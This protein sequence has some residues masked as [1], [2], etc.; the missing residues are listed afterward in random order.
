MRII[1]YVPTDLVLKPFIDIGITDY[2]FGHVP[3]FWKRSYS[4]ANS[5]NRR[6]QFEGQIGPLRSIEGLL[7]KKWG[8]PLNFFLALNNHL[9]TQGQI[10]KIISY[11][12]G[13]FQTGLAGVICADIGLIIALHEQFPHLKIHVS[14]GAPCLNSES[15]KFFKSMGA[16]R[17]ILDRLI[18][19]EEA[20]SIRDKNPGI[21]LEMFAFQEGC[22]HTEGVCAHRHDQNT[23]CLAN[24]NRYLSPK[25]DIQA[26]KMD[27]LLRLHLLFNIGIDYI[28]IPRLCNRGATTAQ[29][30]DMYGSFFSFINLLNGFVM[31]HIE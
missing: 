5:I 9:Y 6:Y 21:E 1:T 19:I 27:P 13:L 2:Y 18:T 31:P 16:G 22:P 26:C 17:V 11:F 30:L 23:N 14:L 28:K 8:K 4:L 7:A 10:E 12:K 3:F 29:M 20:R 25:I 15:V 24:I